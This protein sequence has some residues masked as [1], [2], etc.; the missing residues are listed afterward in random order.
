MIFAVGIVLNTSGAVQQSPQD[1]QKMMEAYMKMAAPNENHAY[2][3]KFVGQWDVTTTAWM[4][5]GAPPVT[6]KNSTTGELI[7][8]GRFLRME[9]KGTM[10]GQPFEGV[11]IIGYDN[12]K[13][14]Y[15][16]LWIDNTSTVFYLTEG[17]RDESTNVLTETGLWPDFMTGGTV[18]ERG[19]I[20]W[21]NPDEYVHETY[22]TGADGKEFKSMEN[23]CVRKK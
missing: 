23:R 5:P 14:K 18:K 16:F 19:T 6:S 12:L 21:L 13:K 15:I 22:M 9:F 4:M 17:S 3:K 11:Q 8:G 1:Q 2:F 7:L 10:F 20:N